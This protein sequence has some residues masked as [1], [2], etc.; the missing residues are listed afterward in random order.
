M[1]FIPAKSEDLRKG[2]Y[3]KL[4]GSWF[5]HPFPSNS[6][7][8]KTNKELSILRGLQKTKIL[9]DPGRSDPPSPDLEET[10]SQNTPAHDNF[11][12]M[13]AQEGDPEPD[14]VLSSSPAS[15]DTCLEDTPA[16]DSLE[17]M[18]AQ[19][20]TSDSDENLSSNPIS[21]E[22][23]EI[24]RRQAFDERRKTLIQAEKKYKEA[25]G[26]NKA[27]IGDLKNGYIRGIVQ[28]EELVGKLNGML[29]DDG[30]IIAL[31][32]L[33]GP[34][35]LGGEFY[36]HSMNVSF[37]SIAIGRQM[38]L[39]E[40]EVQSL[41]VGALLHDIG[42][43]SGLNQFT[44][45]ISSL[46]PSELRTVHRHP[47]NGKLMVDKGFGLDSAA[48]EIIAQHH[49]RLNGSGYPEKLKGD[50][51]HPLAQIVAVVDAFD[52]L[53]NNP[54]IKES[55]TAHEAMAKLY[56]QRNEEFWEKAVEVLVRTLG[57][58]P[59]SSLVELSDGKIGL[60]CT[61]NQQDRLRPQIMLYS[62]DLPR[63]EALIIDLAHEDPDLTIKHSLRPM[64]VPKAAWDYLNPRGMI[65]YF[66]T[67]A[68]KEL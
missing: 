8:I 37:L 50:A 20:E 42:Y 7:K 63:D 21:A 2:I 31:M 11:E 26:Q 47:L 57:V 60:I 25:I 66:A 61:I 40:E 12:E 32:N 18:G 38:N 4:S 13:G 22:E 39:S 55:L 27:L 53:C 24:E 43:L 14:E 10:S 56:R 46:T 44:T 29:A 17:E 59:P 62:P 48:L 36:Y 5:E 28:A 9:Y 68:E 34:K 54:D 49:E 23:A 45:K 1:A 30:S 51:I 3:I 6:F 16:H 15:E 35:E 67:P 52:E 41:G 64:Q 33:M 58:Y 65:S 19:E